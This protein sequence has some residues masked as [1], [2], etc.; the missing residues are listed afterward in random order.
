MKDMKARKLMKKLLSILLLSAN[1]IG[2]LLNFAS[3]DITVKSD[4]SGTTIIKTNEEQK[5]PIEYGKGGIK[6]NDLIGYVYG[7][8]IDT[9]GKI[10]GK[11]DAKAKNKPK[12]LEGT[13]WYKTPS[14]SELL[15]SVR[16]Y[17]PYKV[18]PE[19]EIVIK[20]ATVYEYEETEEYEDAVEEEVME[21]PYEDYAPSTPKYSSTTLQVEGV[22]EADIIK[23]DGKNIYY[24][25]SKNGIAIVDATKTK[26]VQVATLKPNARIGQNLPSY[27]DLYISGN[28]LIIISQK[29]DNNIYQGITKAQSDWPLSMFTSYNDSHTSIDVY[30]ISNP[31]KPNM[32]RHFEIQGSNVKTRLYNNVVYFM[33]N[34]YLASA[35]IGTPII[36]ILPKFQDSA[37]GDEYYVI[38]PENIYLDVYNDRGGINLVT[39][40]AFDIDKN[41]SVE[42]QSYEANN[43]VMFMNKNNIYLA[44]GKRVNPKDYKED[45]KKGMQD[46]FPVVNTDFP[47]HQDT[48]LVRFGINKEKIKYSASAKIKGTVNNSTMINE[49]KNVLRVAAVYQRME[50]KE[51]YY[52]TTIYTMDAGSLSQIGRISNLNKGSSSSSIKYMGD[53][54]YVSN[55]SITPVDLSNPK[56]PKKSAD[57]LLEGFSGYLYSF[58][59]KY[60]IGIG[61]NI[62]DTY[63]KKQDKSDKQIGDRE[64]GVK[65]TL[66]DISKPLKPAIVNSIVVGSANST[67]EARSDYKTAMFDEEKGIMTLPFY[68]RDYEIID[69]ERINDNWNGGLVIEIKPSG[70]RMGATF[71][72]GELQAESGS[73]F[74]YIGNKLYYVNTNYLIEMNYNSYKVLNIIKLKY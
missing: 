62:E 27:N 22:D 4:K 39:L 11:L 38:S 20:E 45:L 63:V 8:F 16:G 67:T 24:L 42:L 25:S 29:S 49:S 10:L 44:L 69:G 74:A 2:A 13:N 17:E 65:F 66:Y 33:V 28:N 59:S 60:L 19:K 30:D 51:R 70:L 53:T 52:Q 46:F 64:G 7:D 1:I 35:Y 55:Y 23:T 31:A 15:N 54:A 5:K 34:N 36:D 18:E 56:A 47:N 72:L 48:I 41:D 43:N 40:G 37:S 71:E 32:K 21:E 68:Y 50:N 6:V 3:T 58:K 12:Q 9:E 57:V 26:P 14:L 73:R 61:T